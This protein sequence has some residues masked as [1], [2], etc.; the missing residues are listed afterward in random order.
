MKNEILRK[1]LSC[2]I[3]GSTKDKSAKQAKELGF[4]MFCFNGGVYSTDEYLSGNDN[5]LF[6]ID[7][8][9]D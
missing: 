7:I 4:K 2:Q 5:K 9:A 1:I 6:D 8:L 3:A